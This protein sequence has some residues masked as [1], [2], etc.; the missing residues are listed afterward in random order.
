MEQLPRRWALS[1]DP[2]MLMKSHVEKVIAAVLKNEGYKLDFIDLHACLLICE[3]QR[4]KIDQSDP[5]NIAKFFTEFPRF[6]RPEGLNPNSEDRYAL[7]PLTSEQYIIGIDA[8]CSNIPDVCATCGSYIN[9]NS[10]FPKLYFKIQIPDSYVPKKSKFDIS[11]N[12]FPMPLDNE[13]VCMLKE[14]E[15]QPQ[16]INYEMQYQ[17]Y[18]TQMY[19]SERCFKTSFLRF[20]HIWVKILESRL[21]I[22]FEGPSQFEYVDD[23]TLVFPSSRERDN[24]VVYAKA[25]RTTPHGMSLLK[26]FIF[27]FYCLTDRQKSYLKGKDLYDIYMYLIDKVIPL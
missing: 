11:F 3:G 8:M 15:E 4:N 5:G 7:Q 23:E 16:Q 9:Y 10:T 1:E 19:C 2:P 21:P 27:S 24:K 25:F 12:D 13:I 14:E 18:D 26:Y 6:N 17:K 20:V 22:Y